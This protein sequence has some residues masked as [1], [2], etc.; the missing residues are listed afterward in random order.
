[1]II[2]VLKTAAFVL[3]ILVI[4]YLGLKVEAGYRLEQKFSEVELNYFKE[5]NGFFEFTYRSDHEVRFVDEVYYL[6]DLVTRDV[7]FQ[8]FR[9][10]DEV[11]FS[12]Y[13]YECV[14]EEEDSSWEGVEICYSI[15]TPESVVTDLNFFVGL[16]EGERFYKY[17]FLSRGEYL[18]RVLD[19]KMPDMDFDLYAEDCF[20]DVEEEDSLSGY[21]CYAK[22]QG[23]V[24]G[25]GG[26]FYPESSINLWGVLK[27]LFVIFDEG[28][29]WYDETKLDPEMFEVMTVYHYAYELMAKSY[30]EGLFVNIH[31]GEIWPNRN[32][33]LEEAEEIIL[34]FVEWQY[35]RNLK[36]YGIEDEFKLTAEV[37]VRDGERYFEFYKDEESLWS[38]GRSGNKDVEL[39]EV[40]DGVEIYFKKEGRVYEYLW[41]FEGVGLDEIEDVELEMNEGRIEAE[42]LVEFADGNVDYYVL[43]IEEDEFEYLKEDARNLIDDP[44]I[45]PNLVSAPSLGG[46]AKVNVSMGAEDF[47]MILKNRTFNTRYPAYVEIDRPGEEAYVQSAVIK[48]RGN[49]NRGYIKPSF[50]IEPFND[51]EFKLRSLIADESMI[52]EKLVYGIMEDLG[53]LAPAFEEAVLEINGVPFGMYQITE[54]I[55]DQFFADR[56]VD[57]DYY[58][59]ARNVTSPYP[60][61]MA[62]QE[63]DEVTLAHYDVYGD[64][65]ADEKLIRFIKAL[66]ADDDSLYEDIDVQNVFDYAMVTFLINA[67]DSLTHNYYLYREDGEWKMFLWD[68]DEGFLVRPE[69]YLRNFEAYVEDH[70]GRYNNL[71]YYVFDNMGSRQFASCFND[72]VRRWI[73]NVDVLDDLRYYRDRY[74]NLFEYDNALWNGKHFERKEIYFDTMSAIDRLEDDFIY[75]DRQVR[76]R[77]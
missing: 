15:E 18:K 20:D 72:F 21:I 32:V 51:R 65:D 29:M 66:D 50:T 45:L 19:W 71:V 76:K 73:R 43:Q 22:L 12:R 3:G 27:L 61:N 5:E 39:I 34:N 4:I 46:V 7:A 14:L 69:T 41:I 1:M 64:K 63:N 47:E 10:S 13:D 37:F 59:Y 53:Y 42:L 24:S 11:E 2:R 52:L 31:G 38:G 6:K 54:P 57:V 17:S 68:A 67:H 56:E 28:D 9:N 33:Y 62:Y 40:D 44:N 26:S 77:F 55:D 58:Y 70:E 35:G 60:A 74:E 30:Y 16:N 23:I 36:N 48:T 49:A 8:V 75:T 25:I